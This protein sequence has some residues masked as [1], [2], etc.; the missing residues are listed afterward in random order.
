MFTDHHI[1]F[2]ALLVLYLILP[3]LQE[4]GFTPPISN[5]YGAR[6]SV[7]NMTI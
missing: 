7:L 1:D 6:R 4:L 2:I 5:V 3:A